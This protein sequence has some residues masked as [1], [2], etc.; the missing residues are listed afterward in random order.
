LKPATA[1]FP[2]YC[3]VDGTIASVDAT[4]E[5]IKFSLALP[6]D[7]NKRLMHLGGGGFNGTVVQP[8]GGAQTSGPMPL[9]RRYAVVGS[10]SG[11]S[12]K[13]GQNIGVFALN[14]EQLRNFTHEQL[15]KTRD[16]ATDL[17]RRRYGAVQEKSYFIGG[18]EGGRESMMVVQRFPADYDGVFTL[19]PVFNWT[20]AM[21]KWLAIGNAMRSNEGAGWLNTAKAKLLLDA[22]VAACDGL[23]GVNDGLISNVKACSFDASTLR[24]SGGADTGDVCLSDAQIATTRVISSRQQFNYSMANG[25]RSV[26]AYDPGAAFVP[27]FYGSMLGS[28]PTFDL[29]SVLTGAGPATLGYVHNFGDAF[30]RFFIMRDANADTLGFDITQPGAHLAR[31]Q[32]VSALVDATSIDI[33]AFMARGGRWI[34]AHGLADPL[35]LASATTEYYES[36]VAKY[37]RAELDKTMRYYTIPGFGHLGGLFAAENGI[38]ALDALEA[39]VERGVAPGHLV[40][41]DTNTGPVNRSRPMC[42]FPAWPK[43]KGSG[44]VNVAS[45]FD[46]VGE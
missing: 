12:S 21:F 24:C 25:F 42:V 7:W 33:S 8:T 34:M 6:S 13:D 18:S 19:F 37:G 39:W 10:D 43:Y 45:S 27:A 46:C 5:P 2:E 29:S 14:D 36:L 28:S 11:H 41:T 15:K 30:T 32:E 9:Q 3:A 16:V 1:D 44:D 35:P 4:A 38:P 26:P 22:E 17:I 40:A 20:S 31:V 23:D